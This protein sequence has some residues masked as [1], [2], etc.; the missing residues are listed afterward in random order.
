MSLRTTTIRTSRIAYR[1]LSTTVPRLDDAQPQAGPSTGFSQLSNLFNQSALTSP[2]APSV[3]QPTPRLAPLLSTDGP[4]RGYLP[5]QLP[6]KVDPVLDLLTNMLMKHG[7]K[8]AA[9][10]KVTKI[11]GLLCVPRRPLHFFPSHLAPISAEAARSRSGPVWNMTEPRRDATNQSPVPLLHRAVFLASPS[12]KVLNMR[13]SMKAVP[14]PRALTERQRTHQAIAWIIKA[15]EKGR[16]A[17]LRRHE[18][19]AREVLAILEGNSEVFKWLEEK[20]KAATLA[21]CVAF[22]PLP[23]GWAEADARSNVMSR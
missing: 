3:P 17:G 19:I 22:G 1:Y 10:A 15:A 16:R 21:R 8:G 9:E 2:A 18:R 23:I 13:K 6:P 14:T 5:S 7:E 12:V 11:L 20:H 4:Q